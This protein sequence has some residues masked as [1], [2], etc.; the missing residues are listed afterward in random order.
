MSQLIDSLAELL[1]REPR[2]KPQPDEIA[3]EIRDIHV[4]KHEDKTRIEKIKI[5][6]A[7]KAQ[8]AAP[9]KIRRKRWE[10]GRASCRERV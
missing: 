1:G 3:P 2:K 5:E 7:H 10:I 9:E 6:M 4:D 8:H